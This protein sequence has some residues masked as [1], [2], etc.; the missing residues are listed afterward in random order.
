ML[1]LIF[2]VYTKKNPNASVVISAM[3]SKFTVGFSSSLNIAPQMA[4]RAMYATKVMIDAS[5]IFR[6]IRFMGVL[7][8]FIYFNYTANFDNCKWTIQ[9]MDVSVLYQCQPPSASKHAR[10]YIFISEKTE[11]F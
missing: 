7:L 4:Y 1:F 6:N 9:L 8:K 5:A 3:I 2:D 11:Y 10:R